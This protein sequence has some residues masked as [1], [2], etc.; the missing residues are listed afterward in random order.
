MRLLPD[1]PR[2]RATRGSP[3]PLALAAALA[4][5]AP[6][7]AQ[8]AAP[9]IGFDWTNTT[10]LSYVET[11]GN[12]SSSTLGAK[13]ALEGKG[14][15]HTWRFEAGGVY[16]SADV[17][18]RRAVG[19]P[20]DFEL[21]ETVRS[22]TTAESY[23]AR[24][25][26][27]RSLGPAFAFGGFGWER[28]TFSGIRH[29]L[30]T[31]AGVGRTFTD[32]PQA[33]FKA[34]LGFTYTIQKDVAP[35]PNADEGFG[36]LRA[37]IEA[38][39]AVSSNAQLRM[40]VV[41]DDNLEE[42]ED[43]RADILTSLSVAISGLQQLGAPAWVQPVFNGTV[44]IVAVGLSGYATRIKA[45]RARQRQLARI[46]APLESTT[47]T[48]LGATVPVVGRELDRVVTIALVITL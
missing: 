5:A 34:D 12:A 47:G 7:S 9:P 39:R 41:L 36:G 28:N 46:D 17:R 24:T 30:S 26:Y 33:R 20:E 35:A 23:F 10:E 37:S 2:L 13:L 3:T 21:V 32:G 22:E 25:R 40:D 14:D 11:G 27:D 16:A 19:T 44:L 38:R 43:L 15:P 42:L 18:S 45:A 29:R 48:P 4:C 6:L 1:F 8:E 31:V